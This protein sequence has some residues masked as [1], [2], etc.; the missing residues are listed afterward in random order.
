MKCIVLG[1]A[2]FIGR[3]VCRELCEHNHDVITLGRTANDQETGSGH[4]A[5]DLFNVDA[6]AEFF[7]N[8]DAVICLA[9]SSLPATAN[10]NLSA[11]ILSHVVPTIRLAECAANS[12]VKRFIF[13]SS[14]GTVYGDNNQSLNS[15]NSITKPIGAYGCSKLAIENYLHVLRRHA[16]IETFSLRISNPY[17]N[18]QNTNKGQGFI[19]AVLDSHINSQPLAI[20]GD[21]SAVRDFLHV[22]DVAAAI[23]R[24]LS[25]SG[26][27]ETFNI[28]SSIGVSLN[29][30]IAEFQTVT[31]TKIDVTYTPGRSFDVKSNVLD[32]QLASIELGWTPQISL[33]QGIEELIEYH[34]RRSV[35]A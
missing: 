29:E 1:G 30:V 3:Y 15:E 16:N 10:E 28:G 20:W 26:N 18:G 21:G 32:N 34:T 24:T 2:G 5:V 19:S 4:Y 9:P 22:K 23:R 13:S 14:G 12:G 11:E 33:R 7:K 25:Y 27:Q 31:N 35:A 17:G 6:T 8:V